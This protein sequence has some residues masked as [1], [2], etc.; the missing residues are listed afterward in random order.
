MDSSG[1]KFLSFIAHLQRVA[2]FRKKKKNTNNVQ[3]VE[4]R[5]SVC[6]SPHIHGVVAVC[7][8]CFNLTSLGVFRPLLPLCVLAV[9]EQVL[10]DLSVLI[11]RMGL[12]IPI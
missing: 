7:L 12:R 2:D 9:D 4:L 8:L 10:P 1:H 5:H 6:D 3:P 11:W